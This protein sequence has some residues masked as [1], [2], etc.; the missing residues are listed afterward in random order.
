MVGKTPTVAIA[1]ELRFGYWNLTVHLS[2][3]PCLI[4]RLGKV[5]QLLGIKRTT[6]KA[7]LPSQLIGPFNTVRPPLPSKYTPHPQVEILPIPAA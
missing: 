4:T 3:K 7:T 2:W 6:S 1:G 5:G